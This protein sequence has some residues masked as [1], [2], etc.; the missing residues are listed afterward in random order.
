MGVQPVTTD[1]QQATADAPGDSQG[2]GDFADLLQEANALEGGAPVPGTPAAEQAQ[3]A[4]L[5]TT[6]AEL[7]SALQM[8]RLLVAPMFQ[9]WP[10]FGDTWNDGTLKG[11][12][13]GGALVMQRHGW[14]MTEAF[15]RFGPYIALAGATLPPTL[16]TWGAI[17][18]ARAAAEKQQQGATRGGDS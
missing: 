11:I 18:Q 5:A 2:N 13:T 3:A 16:A 6:T 10:H 12:A 8:A 1:N 15:E 14:T 9:W 17:K 4:D 7:E